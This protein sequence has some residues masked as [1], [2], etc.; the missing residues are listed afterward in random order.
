[1]AGL[2]VWVG[3]LSHV[4]CSGEGAAG[5]GGLDFLSF[6]ILILVRGCLVGRVSLSLS[7][8]F[9]LSLTVSLSVSLSFFFFLSLS[10]SLFLSLSLSLSCSCLWSGSR[11]RCYVGVLAGSLYPWIRIYMYIYI[12][13]YIYLGGCW[14]TFAHS[15]VRIPRMDVLN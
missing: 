5:R 7:V 2:L 15:P 4:F 6:Y 14:L 10:L 3:S 12:Y 11:Y 1:M 13:I 9:S 8:S